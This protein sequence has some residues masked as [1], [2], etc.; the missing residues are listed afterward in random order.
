MDKKIVILHTF[1]KKT[2]K[3]PKTAISMAKT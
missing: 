3:T 1:I 2:E